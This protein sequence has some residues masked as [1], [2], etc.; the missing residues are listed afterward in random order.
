MVAELLNKYIWLVQ[1]FITAGDA[2]LSLDE[3]LNAW[4]RKFG[5]EYSRRSF[6]NHREAVA[7][8]FGI[9]IE[10]NRSTRRYFVRNSADIADRD[11]GIAW[12]IDTFTVNNLLSLSKERLSGRISVEDIPSGKKYLTSLMNAMQENHAVEITYRKYGASEP[13]T[14]RVH[15]Y[16][17]KESAHRWYLVGWSEKHG[18]C[19]VFALDRIE[20]LKIMP[21]N[22]TMPGDFDIDALF[23]TSFGTYL[24]D[25]PGRKIVF[26]AFGTEAFYIKDLPLHRSQTVI[27]EDEK[28]TTFSIFASP[29][30]SLYLE[31]LGHGPNIEVIEPEDVRAEMKALISEMEKLYI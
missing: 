27:K 11:T 2:G 15:P 25:L 17:I 16:G 8:V 28:S 22:F 12:L 30:K 3:I 26:R 23:A 14:R 6:N 4:T 31:M 24:S 9:E 20:T 21:E 10:C 7:N 5:T 13:E 18:Q 19:R 29:N 1:K